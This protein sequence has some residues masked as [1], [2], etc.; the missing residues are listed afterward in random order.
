MPRRLQDIPG[1][2]QLLQV[3]DPDD[4]PLDNEYVGDET[5][6][7][8]MPTPDQNVVDEI[9]EAYGIGNRESGPLRS[10]AEILEDRDRHRTD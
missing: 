8:S 10:A 1:Q 4:W 2:D 3:G 6:G 5:P 9:G 7:G